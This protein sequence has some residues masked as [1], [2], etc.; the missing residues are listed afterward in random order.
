MRGGSGFVGGATLGCGVLVAGGGRSC[1]S[2]PGS[3]TALGGGTNRGAFVV[4]GLPG[5]WMLPIVA[6]EALPGTPAPM[7]SK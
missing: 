2:G 6:G 1:D 7:R 3:G 5:N 4:G